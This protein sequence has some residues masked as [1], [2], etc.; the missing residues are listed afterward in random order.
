M[1]IKK[2]S[3][4]NEYLLTP[5]GMWVRNF[6]KHLVP[7]VD[8]N[9]L[10]RQQDYPVLLQNETIN[11]RSRNPWVDR[12]TFRHDK[13]V[14][15]SDGHH[16]NAVQKVLGR[17]DK[18]VTIIAVNAALKKWQEARVPAYYVVNNPYPECLH[19][20]PRIFPRCIAS[21]RTNHE[22]LQRYRGIK[23]RYLP[24]GDE[25]YSGTKGN[26]VEYQI[27]DYRNPI[28]AAIC[29]AYRFNLRKLLLACCDDSFSEERPGAEQLPNGL[30]Q[31]PQQRIGQGFI[32]GCMYWL[33][34][35][36]QEI[37]IRSSSAGLEYEN[38]PY[39]RPEEIV[40]FFEDKN[41]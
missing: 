9:N 8:I 32:D 27:D 39:I 11:N 10:T 2:H 5:T 22:F 37:K 18:S 24:V 7:Y 41:G 20:M 29:I 1:I 23:Y 31:Y 16:F 36:D 19:F 14:I 12:E 33:K 26:E 17:L 4:K 28:C 34:T 38:A 21:V 13:V 30:W 3:N 15:V 25:R 35:S 6:T 40:T